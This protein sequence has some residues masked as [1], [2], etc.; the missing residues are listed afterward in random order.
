MNDLNL[1]KKLENEE[2]DYQGIT[3]ITFFYKILVQGTYKI[4]VIYDLSQPL[5][6][7]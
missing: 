5:F 6:I 7:S 4:F 1:N 2:Q 3:R